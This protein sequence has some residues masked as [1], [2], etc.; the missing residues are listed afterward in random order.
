MLAKAVATSAF[1]YATWV[2]YNCPCKPLLGCHK[3]TIFCSL[4]WVAA[5]VAYDSM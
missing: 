3:E 5:A 1:A 4:L 2:T